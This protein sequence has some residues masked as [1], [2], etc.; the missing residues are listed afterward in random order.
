M[1]PSIPALTLKSDSL[2]VSPPPR[3]SRMTRFRVM[4]GVGAALLLL[5]LGGTHPPPVLWA[6]EG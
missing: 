3:L 4:E 5:V 6:Q 1:L 2:S